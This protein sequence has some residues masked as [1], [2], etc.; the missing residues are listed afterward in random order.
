MSSEFLPFHQATIGEEEV[1]EIIQT[2]HSGWLTTGPK[3]RLFE[4]NFAGYIGCK[5]AIG[6]V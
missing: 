3:T 5:H 1:K 6:R 2:L 4:K